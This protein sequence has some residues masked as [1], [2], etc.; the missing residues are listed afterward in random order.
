MICYDLITSV[1]RRKKP[2]SG[3]IAKEKFPGSGGAG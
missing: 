1:Q 3:R 2:D